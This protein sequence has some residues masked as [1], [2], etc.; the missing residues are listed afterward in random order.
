MIIITF[1]NSAKMEFGL[2]WR[3]VDDAKKI[4]AKRKANVKNFWFIVFII[5]DGKVKL[6]WN[7]IE[8]FCWFWINL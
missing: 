3:K 7:Y 6:Y 8:N 4:W 5:R 2:L 1:F